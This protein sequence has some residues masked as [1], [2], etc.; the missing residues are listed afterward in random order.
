M[1]V[2]AMRRRKKKITAYTSDSLQHS[3][4][5]SGKRIF[6]TVFFSFSKLKLEG[7]F[8]SEEISRVVFVYASS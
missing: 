6:Q 5:I 3:L 7:D 8:E 4:A 2:S 1:G